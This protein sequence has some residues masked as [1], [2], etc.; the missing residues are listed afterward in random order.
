MCPLACIQSNPWQRISIVGGLRPQT[1]TIR[2]TLATL[3]YQCFRS[4]HLAGNVNILHTI[5][6]SSIHLLSFQ[7]YYLLVPIAGEWATPADEVCHY[8]NGDDYAEDWGPCTLLQCSCC[9]VPCSRMPRATHSD[10]DACFCWPPA[11]VAA[12]VL[13]P[14][15]TS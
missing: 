3:Q 12:A 14:R 15:C 13:L 6:S 10:L 4:Q 9:Q 7:Q 8:C 5:C 11:Y 1:S 2:L